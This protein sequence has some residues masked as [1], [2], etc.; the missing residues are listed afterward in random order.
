MSPLSNFQGHGLCGS[1]PGPHLPLSTLHPCPR[2][3]Q[4]LTRGQRGEL[5][6]SLFGLAPFHLAGF[7][8][9]TGD[10]HRKVA[11]GCQFH[12]VRW[13]GVKSYVFHHRHAGTRVRRSCGNRA[14]LPAPGPHGRAGAPLGQH[15][16]LRRPGPASPCFSKQ[17]QGRG[18]RLE[19]VA[20]P[21][22]VL[23]QHR[24]PVGQTGMAC[25]VLSSPPR[26]PAVRSARH[27]TP[28]AMRRPRGADMYVC[29]QPPVDAGLRLRLAPLETLNRIEKR[30]GRSV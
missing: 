9:R 1:M 26:P 2:E 8:R 12:I 20:E 13:Y 19:K 11:D 23:A 5:F 28:C 10:P 17:G 25:I 22:R 4:H 30:G 6:L 3:Q 18:F 29:R 15:P 21:A 16:S 24:T 7:D 14:L 27:A